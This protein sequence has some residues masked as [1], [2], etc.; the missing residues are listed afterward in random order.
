MKS[1]RTKRFK[2]LFAALPVSAQRDANEAYRH[3]RTDPAHP[4]LHF[5]QVNESLAVYSARVGIHYRALAI[6]RE[7]HWLWF[8]IGT[9]AEYDRLLDRM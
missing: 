3:F 9:H 6:R 2:V 4:G 7:D 1:K 8:W 5:R